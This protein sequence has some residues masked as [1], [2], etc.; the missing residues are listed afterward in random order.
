MFEIVKGN[1]VEYEGVVGGEGYGRVMGVYLN[2]KGSVPLP[3]LHQICNS[4]F[5]Y[6]SHP[7]D[8]AAVLDKGVVGVDVEVVRDHQSSAHRHQ[9]NSIRSKPLLS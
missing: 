7:T 4:I 3:Y 2:L 5:P 9:R 1:I 8:K 6:F